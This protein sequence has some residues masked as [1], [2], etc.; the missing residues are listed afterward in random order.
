[1]FDL[2]QINLIFILLLFWAQFVALKLMNPSTFK[3]NFASDGIV[4]LLSFMLLG[5][6]ETWLMAINWWDL[7]STSEALDCSTDDKFTSVPWDT[8]ASKYGIY[9]GCFFS[10]FL[11]L[12]MWWSST[13][14]LGWFSFSN[15]SVIKNICIPARGMGQCTFFSGILQ[16]KISQYFGKPLIRIYQGH[17]K[18][19]YTISSFLVRRV[20]SIYMDKP[21]PKSCGLV[22][23]D[24]GSLMISTFQRQNI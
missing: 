11:C 13:S 12:Y 20:N 16:L 17:M 9:T 4:L 15:S 10:F 23:Y 3:I 1:M 21:F 14:D 2:F 7:L 18:T 24:A 5:W 8:P 6:Y 22:E 19:A